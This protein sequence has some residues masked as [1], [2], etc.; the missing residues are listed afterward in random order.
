M[1][2]HSRASMNTARST[3]SRRSVAPHAKLGRQSPSTTSVR[4]VGTDWQACA[5]HASRTHDPDELFYSDKFNSRYRKL[6]NAFKRCDQGTKKRKCENDED[7][8]SQVSDVTDV[9]LVVQLQ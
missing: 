3:E 2:S 9:D 7:S 8:T 5:D 1:V 4:T 6:D